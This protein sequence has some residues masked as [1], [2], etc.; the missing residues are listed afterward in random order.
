M[1]DMLVNTRSKEVL[2]KGDTLPPYI[3]ADSASTLICTALFPGLIVLTNKRNI[4]LEWV[5]GERQTMPPYST[6][7]LKHYKNR[8]I[9]LD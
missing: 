9:R 8:I 4:T 7:T 2:V 3:T 5:I 1:S 6:A